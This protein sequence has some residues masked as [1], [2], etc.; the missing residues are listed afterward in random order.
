MVADEAAARQYQDPQAFQGQKCP[1]TPALILPEAVPEKI[2]QLGYK[3][4]KGY[5]VTIPRLMAEGIDRGIVLFISTVM[6]LPVFLPN[7]LKS[8]TSK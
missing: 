5:P 6:A 3:V 4:P 7:S 8:A 2:L 1:W